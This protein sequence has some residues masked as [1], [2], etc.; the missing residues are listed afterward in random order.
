MYLHKKIIFSIFGL[1]LLLFISIFIGEISGRI[2]LKGILAIPENGKIIDIRTENPYI[3]K[4]KPFV[5]SHIPY[6]EYTQRGIHFS[7]SYKINSMGLR[8]KDAPKEKGNK[9]RLL[10]IGDSVTEGHGVEMNQ[11]YVALLRDLF[12]KENWEV[13][14]AGIQGAGAAHQA[15]NL[16]RYFALAPDAV[17]FAA[18]ENDLADDR[19][20]EIHYESYPVI[21]NPDIFH[22]GSEKSFLS[23]SKLWQ[24]T[25]I[26]Y[27]KFLKPRNDVEKLIKQ[28]S[29][30]IKK[31][32]TPE[33]LQFKSLSFLHPSVVESASRMSF[34]YYDY[35]IEQTRK[36]KIPFFVV[37]LT[38]LPYREGFDPT[39]KK[40]SD[41]FNSLLELHLKEKAIPYL[42]IKDSVIN[43]MKVWDPSSEK[44]IKTSFE[45]NYPLAIPEDGHPSEIGHKLF[46]N[47]IYS[48]LKPQM[49]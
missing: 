2:F 13:I 4:F 3:L 35:F 38:Y 19:R 25:Y 34:L 12:E 40:S 32:S 16:S 47:E 42:D 24:M 7:V 31:I 5:H 15:M 37:N 6:S 18:Y 29:K 1:F 41:S 20:V 33:Q 45:K 46:A 10:I 14:N 43:F 27:Y 22:L 36:R 21:E 30:L 23:N 17:L 48:W 39:L 44:E 9:K 26:F 8:D 28:N 11:T 49:Y